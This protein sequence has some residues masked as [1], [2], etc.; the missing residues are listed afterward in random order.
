M[1]TE[2]RRYTRVDFDAE[3]LI[4]QNSVSYP[5]KIID[6]S[7]NGILL[8]PPKHYELRSD[9]PADIHIRLSEED[10]IHMRVTLVHSSHHVLGFQCDS[11]GMES[12]THLRKIIELNMDDPNASERVLAELITPR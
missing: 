10:T 9:Q 5:A 3:A 4:S 6:V 11:I 7:L 12:I 1:N 8:E 2:R